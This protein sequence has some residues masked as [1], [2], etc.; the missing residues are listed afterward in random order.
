V[1]ETRTSAEEDQPPASPAESLRLIREQR[2][3]AERSLTPDPRLVYWPWAT[4]WLVGFGAIF[5]RYGSDGDGLIAMP[6]WV[7]L[8]ILFALMVVAMVIMIVGLFR[9]GRQ[10]AGESATKGTMYGLS[11]AMGYAGLGV[12]A[13]YLSDFLPP[14]QVGLMWAALSISVVSVLYI[15]G[16]AIYPAPTMFRFGLWLGVVNIVGVIAGPGWHSLIIS[17]AGGGGGYVFG[18]L[19]WRRLARPARAAR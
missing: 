19:A 4:A 8:A 11:W 1:D 7:P 6:G 5:L 3:H 15:A 17:L 2:A 16:A 12:T 9:A 10:V 13:G 18:F 14:A